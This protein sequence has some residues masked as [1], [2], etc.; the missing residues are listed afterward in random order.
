MTDSPSYVLSA[1]LKKWTEKLDMTS[2]SR[3]IYKDLWN[4]G[5]KSGKLDLLT[6]QVGDLLHEDFPPEIWIVD[7]LIPDKSVT[8]LSGSP[9][10]FKTWLYMEIAVKVA[11]GQT[12]FGNFNT[13][14]TSV[15]VIDEESGRPRLQK[16]FK[17][18]G[19]MDD[20]PIYLM[21]RVGYKMNQLYADGIAEKAQELGAGL[22]IFDSLTRFMGEKTDEN[23]SGDMAKLMDYYRQLADAGLSVLI[24]HHN[25][26]ENAGSFNPAQSL[27]GS[28]DILASVDCHIAVNRIGQSE[29]VK[30]TQTK[31][32]DIW[33]PTPFELRFQE[34]AS[35]FE[36][37]GAGK[38]PLEKHRELLD[39][40]LEVVTTL[41]G[42]TKTQLTKQAK[43]HGV[44]GGLKKIGD[45]ID[46]L[47]LNGEV[48]M[49]EADR[50]GQKYYPITSA[51]KTQ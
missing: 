32:R 21:S 1:L 41:P 25:R 50:K 13:K 40:V 27:R 26:K 47:T 37:L 15:L 48:D 5:Q 18:L 6:E 10:S 49:R 9:G 46:E 11:K 44:K 23:A 35:E 43:A 19:A 8:I 20:L 12:A 38:T 31:N 28:S 39:H 34:N 36:Y 24:L 16:R 42:L 22:V 29:S 14:Q 30:L 17:Q 3:E 2:L 7:Q 33:E 4:T 51:A 45:L